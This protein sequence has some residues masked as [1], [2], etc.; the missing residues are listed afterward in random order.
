M[1]T[2]KGIFPGSRRFEVRDNVLDD[3]RQQGSVKNVMVRT[4]AVDDCLSC[5]SHL[6]HSW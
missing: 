3:L 2:G 5:S 4:I 1:G 6:S